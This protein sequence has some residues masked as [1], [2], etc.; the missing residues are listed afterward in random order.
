MR[1]LGLKLRATTDYPWDGTIRF[2]I[3]ETP[4]K[5]L[6]FK[7]R[8][9]SWTDRAS[10]RIN[11]EAV[12][13]ETTPGSYS[14]IS[15]VWRQGDVFELDLEMKTRLLAGHPRS[16]HIRN[17]VA[18]KRGPVVYCLESNDVIGDVPF[19]QI[20]IDASAE[21]EPEYRSD[22]LGGVTVLRTTAKAMAKP[23]RTI[24][25]QYGDI[26]EQHALP[27][28]IEMIPYFAWNNR[29]EPKMSVWPPLS[30]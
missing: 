4:G 26:T 16:E 11:G 8:I 3:E 21:F 20:A 10:I 24:I 13:V 25:G 7:L 1:K 19:E 5:T 12:A 2:A 22:L 17:Q 28:D 29:D 14:E 6:A 27:V 15:R 9:P 23:Q 30:R 18:V